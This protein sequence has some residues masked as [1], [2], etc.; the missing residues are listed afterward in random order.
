[1]TNRID[2]VVTAFVIKWSNV[3]VVKVMQS[4]KNKILNNKHVQNIIF[5]NFNTQTTQYYSH[6]VEV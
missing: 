4:L 1:M 6:M 3:N 5:Y 2:N